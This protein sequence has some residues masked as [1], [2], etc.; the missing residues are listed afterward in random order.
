MFTVRLT[1]DAGAGAGPGF[2]LVLFPGSTASRAA[3]FFLATLLATTLMDVP[4]AAA[5]VPALAAT[6]T[7]APAQAPGAAVPDGVPAA[8]RIPLA[9]MA[10]HE[11]VGIAI[12]RHPDIG[13][14]NAVVAQS[15]A[16]IAVA[17]AAWYPKLE[18]GVRPGYG[19]SFGSG[20]NDVGARA[21][22][23]V[24]QL[25]YDFGRTASKISA[26]DASLVQRR[27]ELS[28]TVEQIA[29]NTASIYIELAASQ[30]VM[31]AAQRQLETLAVTRDKIGQRVRAGLSVSSDGT[32][33]DVA[34]QRA[35]TEV[36]RARTRF[37][38]A[39]SRLAELIGVRPARVAELARTEDEIRGLGD[40]GDDIE[41][42]P[43]VL[44]AAAAA[45]AA[46]AR[47]SLAEAERF[48][49]VSVGVS[50]SVSTGRANAND[51]TWIGV[52]IAGD[53]S[54][55]GLNRHRID[56]AR[57]G[58]RAAQ[59]ALDN[60]RLLARTT[61][62]S[63]ATEAAGA[64]AR[65]QSYAQMIALLRASRDL[66]WQEYILNKRTLTDVLNPEREIFLAEQEWI[67]AVADGML[68]RIKAHA[69]T[70]R[71][72]ALL[73]EHDSASHP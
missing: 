4:A 11:A 37:D 46:H 53:F 14:A 31:A 28:D 13:R 59:Q 38:V 54:L 5:P 19:G 1:L 15:E 63:A 50:R 27:H 51:D 35:R 40:E 67:G 45:A 71:F 56:A 8:L 60:E 17:R 36:L 44:A 58:Q 16:E 41:H 69:A 23:G 33:A 64:A 18:Y 62:N 26:A 29:Y 47:V 57:A 42:T 6:A 30:A 52:A 66:Y 61:L 34:I 12:S 2:G 21:S 72:V 7:L 55:G 68:A 65:T 49:S 10:L 39:A 73:R 3:G 20:G 25:L 32:M 48:P 9:G 70:G 24:S 43:K 22:V